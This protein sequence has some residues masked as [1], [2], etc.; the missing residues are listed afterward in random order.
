M[1]KEVSAGCTGTNEHAFFV[2]GPKHTLKT[3]PYFWSEEQMMASA[4]YN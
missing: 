3:Y 1:Q 4:R 2:E